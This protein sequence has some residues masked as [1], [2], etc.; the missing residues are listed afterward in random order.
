LA[1]ESEEAA[2]YIQERIQITDL[3]KVKLLEYILDHTDGID[4]IRPFRSPY[5][6][7]TEIE[8]KISELKKDFSQ[9]LVQAKEPLLTEIETLKNNAYSPDNLRVSSQAHLIFKYHRDLD[10]AQE[11]KK[12]AGRIGT[13][14]RGIGP[15]YVD[16]F[17]RRGIRVGDL[18]NQKVLREKLAWNLEEKS[19]MLNQF[20][21]MNVSY[22]LDEIVSTY[23]GYA[24][25]IKKHVVEESS[26]IIH[27][28]IADKK[29]ILMEGA[30]GTMLDVDHG[31]YPYVTSS[32][33]ISG[34][35]CS[36]A[37]IPPAGRRCGWESCA[38]GPA[39]RLPRARP[40]L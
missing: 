14:C 32:N 36:G 40:R 34:G 2:N 1:E 29:E 17:N 20:Y 4:A 16:K 13:T 22:N 18:Y 37:G 30:Q 38:T 11:K 24:H 33:P 28:A 27:R 9:K 23:I 19:F 26:P 10:A 21:N 31:T 8:N 15:C 39:L 25:A 5:T 12:E 6:Y 35:A 3:E 7:R